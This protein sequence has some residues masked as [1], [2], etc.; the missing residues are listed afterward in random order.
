M[1]PYIFWAYGLA[2]CR[3]TRTAAFMYVIP[4]FALGWTALILGDP[5]TGIAIAG[6]AVVLA[7]VALTQA[8]ARSS[9]A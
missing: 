2:A 8:R 1:L 9:P 5:P 4:C 3:S 6:G 7:G